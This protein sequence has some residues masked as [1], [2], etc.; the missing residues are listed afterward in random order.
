M[1]ATWRWVTRPGAHSPV[2]SS[3]MRNRGALM[4]VLRA[5]LGPLPVVLAVSTANIL[6][7]FLSFSGSLSLHLWLFLLSL[8]V[9]LS[10]SLSLFS[11]L[12][13]SQSLSL[14]L[15]SSS[16]VSP[17]F[18]LAHPRPDPCSPLTTHSPS[19]RTAAWRTPGAQESDE[20]NVVSGRDPARCHPHIAVSLGHPPESPAP[21]LRPA[22]SSRPSWSI[23][24]PVSTC[25]EHSTVPPQSP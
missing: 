18:S 15:F 25:Q 7:L 6:S 13:M 20:A 4:R 14:S 9:H 16:S 24:S 12:P 8:L 23:K 3:P 17:F 11:S 2:V 10:P 5:I 19:G 21:G 1:R 22:G